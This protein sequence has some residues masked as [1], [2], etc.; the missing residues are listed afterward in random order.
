MESWLEASSLCLHSDQPPRKKA[1]SK[2]PDSK[3]QDIK[4]AEKSMEPKSFLASQECTK[5]GHVINVMQ[6]KLLP[7]DQHCWLH[8]TLKN[9]FMPVACKLGISTFGLSY[10][11]PENVYPLFFSAAEPFPALP[12]SFKSSSD[13][14]GRESSRQ[15]AEA[16]L[17][18][19]LLIFLWVFH[20]APLA[21]SGDALA[22]CDL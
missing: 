14:L 2:I 16:H 22:S 9:S 8:R 13:E 17:Q 21:G 18:L 10:R 4:V 6:P 7:V 11:P 3:T 15:Q 5:G 12:P 20:C 1:T 19:F